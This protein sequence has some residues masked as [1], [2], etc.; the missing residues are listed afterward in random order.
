MKSPARFRIFEDPDSACARATDAVADLIRERAILGRKVV[1]GLVAGDTSLPFFKELIYRHR[2][3]GLSLRNVVTFNTDEYVGIDGSHPASM[4]A[5]MQRH[6]FDHVD[7]PPGAV[8]FPPT[9]GNSYELDALC[10]KHDAAV[11][12]A[13]GI[14]FQ[15]LSLRLNGS[16][17]PH[18]PSV[19]ADGPTQRVAIRR[20]GRERMA[21]EF[22]GIEN[23]PTHIVSVGYRTILRSRKIIILAWGARKAYNVR[24]VIKGPI[25]SA[26]SATYL[27]NHPHTCF[28]LDAPAGRLIADD[29]EESS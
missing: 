29:S 6:L 4:R 12:R 19:P 11:K 14:D 15:V 24:R 2:E 20:L 17:G 1:L 28:F 18:H 3:E 26:A 7:I 5:F 22:G 23:V 21:A 16:L 25:T 27:Q 9:T 8:H 10:A 13:R